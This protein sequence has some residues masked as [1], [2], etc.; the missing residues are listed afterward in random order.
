[1]LEPFGTRT[2]AVTRSGREVSGAT[3]GYS[4]DQTEEL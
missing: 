3:A 1:M 4:A 2:L